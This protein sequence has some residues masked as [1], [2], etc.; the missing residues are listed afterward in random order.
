MKFLLII[1]DFVCLKPEEPCLRHSTQ[2][3]TDLRLFFLTRTF[4]FLITFLIWELNVL[5]FVLF[6]TLGLTL[7]HINWGK[8]LYN[9]VA[10]V[11]KSKWVLPSVRTASYHNSHD[12]SWWQTGLQSAAWYRKET[13]EGNKVL[14]N[15]DP[16]FFFQIDLTAQNKAMSCKIQLGGPWQGFYPEVFNH[17]AFVTITKASKV[18][19]AGCT[20]ITMFHDT[21]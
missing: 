6:D 18:W 7:Y 20:S 3:Q 9:V 10:C 21:K 4:C 16:A 2:K 15:K 13:V 5:V 8:R 14:R 1:S 19:F 12:R 11:L 17:I